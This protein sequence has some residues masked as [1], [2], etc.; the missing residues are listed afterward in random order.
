MA[1]EKIVKQNADVNDTIE[2]IVDTINKYSQSEYV[3]QI[4]A[5]L[6]KQSKGSLNVFL[7]SLFNYVCTQVKYQL[8]PINQER[9]TTPERLVRDGKGDCKKMSV[10]IASVLKCAG[11]EP[12]LKVISYDGTNY[13]HIYVIV[14]HTDG[15]ISI[16]DPVNNCKYNEEIPHVKSRVINLK[17]QDMPQLSLLGKPP[18]N[19]SWNERSGNFINPWIPQS[20]FL[21]YLSGNNVLP[22]SRFITYLHGPF[23]EIDADIQSLTFNEGKFIDDT[24]TRFLTEYRPK[25]VQ[26][27]WDDLMLKVKNKA[28][29]IGLAP[30]RGAFLLLLKFN[31]FGIATRVSEA[32]NNKNFEAGQ[33]IPR[34]WISIGGS[35][36]NDFA[37]LRNAVNEGRL[38][39]RP[40]LGEPV[41]IAAAI[42]AA[43][44]VVASLL[45]LLKDK[46]VISQQTADT[47]AKGTV[48]VL[49]QQQPIPDTG[50]N[51]DDKSEGMGIG[52]WLLLA[53][54]AGLAYKVVT[55][56]K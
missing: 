18:Y 9:V 38:R 36:D 33:G 37:I 43:A 46:G 52:S 24:M 1:W 6:S 45:A 3:K 32:W 4:T 50:A 13:E 10:Y 27:W 49:N 15:H 40:G 42:T 2:L 8:D 48:D 17:N 19:N 29:E 7:R 16:L 11:I 22:Q 35:A 54:G 5:T 25:G 12:L 51:M 30:G 39:G 20:R 44:P 31:V 28:K 34:W 53:A 26:G 21:N 55:S 41:S 56:K 47:I 23:A 14:Q